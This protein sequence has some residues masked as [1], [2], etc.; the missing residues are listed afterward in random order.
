MKPVRSSAYLAFVRRQ[1]CAVCEKRFG[2]EACHTG[3]HGISQKAPDTSAI[4]LCRFHHRDEREGLDSIGRVKFE[5]LHGVTVARIILDVQLR[6]DACGVK[7]FEKELTER[8][9]AERERYV[10]PRYRVG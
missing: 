1:P 4:P 5:R 8:K 2:V 3:P 6:A 9:P 10:S 7:V